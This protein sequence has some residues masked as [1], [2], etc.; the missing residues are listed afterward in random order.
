MKLTGGRKLSSSRTVCAAWDPGVEF[1]GSQLIPSKFFLT[2]SPIEFW[3]RKM[4]ILFPGMFEAGLRPPV[5][6]ASKAM[7]IFE[8][9]PIF[10]TV[11]ST[12]RL[13]IVQISQKSVI[14]HLLI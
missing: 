4:P 12:R 3:I 7:Y 11:Y 1:A 8:E 2:S 13:C 5:C 14:L 10:S 6:L 9:I